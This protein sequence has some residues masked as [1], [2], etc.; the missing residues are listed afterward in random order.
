ML[1]T[2]IKSLTLEELQ[3]FVVKLGEN[4]FRAKQIFEW[5]HKKNAAG[6]DEMTNISISLRQKLSENASLAVSKIEKKLVSEIDGTVKYLLSFDDGECVESVL[7]K[8]NHGNSLCV[9]TQAGCRMGCSFCASTINGLKRSLAPSEI[10]EQVYV[11]QRDLGREIDSIVL[12]GIGEPLDNY[13]NV[14]KFL[15][16]LSCQDGRHMSLRHVSLSTCGLVDRINMLAKENLQLTLSISLHA[17]NDEIRN[18]IM[19]VNNRWHIG[20]LLNACKNYV[21]HT[22]RRISF[23]YAMIDGVNDSDECAVELASKLRGILCHVNIIPANEVSE[24]RHKNSSK[25]RIDRFVEIL[26]KK[27]VNV[28]VRR[29]LGSDI[30]A[31]C[32][33]LRNDQVSLG[34]AKT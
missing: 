25:E 13:D 26:S 9:S 4:K 23:E 5:I 3:C 16:L 15:K 30:N 32:G 18:K 8:Y 24:K 11:A 17:P 33:Q 10:L 28:T 31:A 27:G 2:D 14:L 19:P 7:M 20:S 34:G 6:F 12:M 22:G 29:K 1:K 21:I